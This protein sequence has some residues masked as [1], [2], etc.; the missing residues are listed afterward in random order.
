MH[1]KTDSELVGNVS[2]KY[3]RFNNAKKRKMKRWTKEK[4]MLEYQILYEQ[5][6]REPSGIFL[7]KN[8]HGDLKNAI[9]TYFG[10][11]VTLRKE[12]GLTTHK[13]PTH[14][15]TLEKTLQEFNMFLSNN[16]IV[17]KTKSVYGTLE[18]QKLHGLR[19]AI[20]QWG[21]LRKL[22]KEH[23]LGLTLQGE[24]WTREKVLKEL[25]RLHNKGISTTQS[26]L[27]KIERDDLLGAINK[28][29]TLNSLKEELG[30]P[31][32]R[33]NYWT[34][35]KIIDELKPIIEEL[36]V[37]P[38]SLILNAIEIGRASCRERV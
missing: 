27:K 14:Y 3:A 31:F 17:L 26:N 10:G 30:I 18:T 15:W 37:M 12:M 8:G 19:T 29:G 23:N 4:V 20:G 35:D 38:S 5:I 6:G 1:F 36:G 11:I 28:Y 34:D 13:K 24:K 33:Q 7:Y 25:G 32:S 21:G 2:K 16:R 22:N 9:R